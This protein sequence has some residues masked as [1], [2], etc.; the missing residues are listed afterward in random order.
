[1]FTHPSDKP[2]EKLAVFH[3]FLRKARLKWEGFQTEPY[4]SFEPDGLASADNGRLLYCVDPPFQD[5]SSTL[6]INRL[7][8][9]R[10][11]KALCHA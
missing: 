9:L 4:F 11:E 7:G 6:V 1:M 5:L 8:R 2:G 3:L 10:F